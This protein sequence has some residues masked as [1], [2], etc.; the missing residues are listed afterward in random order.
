MTVENLITEY[1][2]AKKIKKDYNF[3]Q[4]IKMTYMP[5]ADKCALVKSI[6]EQ[7][8]Y[9]DTPTGKVYRRDTSH[10][11]FLFTIQ[12]I[13]RYTDIEIEPNNVVKDYD[14]LMESGT[15]NGLMAQIPQEENAILSGMMD[16]TRDDL[17]VNTRGIVPYLE[18]KDSLIMTFLDGFE[19]AL[20]RPEIRERI[21]KMIER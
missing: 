8:S 18:T 14:S 10:M 21:E 13:L 4:H 2:K 19:K 17:E 20:N 15:M 6:V 1:E 3:K 5:Y 16:M 11:L 7:T 9:V 12:L